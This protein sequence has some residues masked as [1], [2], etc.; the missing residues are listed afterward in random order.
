[1]LLPIPE[2][3]WSR[4]G[5]DFMAWLPRSKGE[6][7]NCIVTIIDHMTKRAQWFGMKEETLAE[8]FAWLFMD[9]YVRLHLHGVPEQIVP[10]RDVRFMS[11]FWRALWRQ[12]GTNLTPSAP[13][14]PKL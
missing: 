6:G 14:H 2:G 3:R 10:D 4:I 9:K 1:M 8:E 13:F 11:E 5:I 12:L 7:N